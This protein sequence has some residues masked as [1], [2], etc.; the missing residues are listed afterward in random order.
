[1]IHAYQIADQEV[2]TLLHLG[3]GSPSSYRATRMQT[4]LHCGQYY[5]HATQAKTAEADK[6]EHL[7]GQEGCV[8]RHRRGPRQRRSNRE[9]RPEIQSRGLAPLCSAAAMMQSGAEAPPYCRHANSAP[10]R[11]LIPSCSFQDERTRGT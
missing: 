9:G 7:Q 3:L 5:R 10:S 11:S 2:R 4:Y 8:A 1:M 6:L